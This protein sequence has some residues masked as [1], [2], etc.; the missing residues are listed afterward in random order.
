MNQERVK[1]VES[2]KE[3]HKIYLDLRE[4]E[5]KKDPHWVINNPLK[6]EYLNEWTEYGINLIMSTLN[7]DRMKA[8]VEMAWIQ[9]SYI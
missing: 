5:T 1:I 3:R 8:E 2:L 7:V 6:G 9:A 4:E